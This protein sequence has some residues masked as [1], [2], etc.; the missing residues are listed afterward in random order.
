MNWKHSMILYGLLII[1]NILPAI[2]GNIINIAAV[3]FITT[4]AVKT[5][6]EFR[7][8]SN[9]NKSKKT[10]TDHEFLS[11]SKSYM[12]EPVTSDNRDDYLDMM[13]KRQQIIDDA[14]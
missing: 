13:Y 12:R 9:M 6:Y 11:R 7:Q 2:G 3:V 5:Y 10:E 1:P 8:E 14:R 4:L